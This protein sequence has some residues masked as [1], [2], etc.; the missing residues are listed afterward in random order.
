M[1]SPVYVGAF[2]PPPPPEVEGCDIAVLCCL[3]YFFFFKLLLFLK[4]L[5]IR[6]T[7]VG[8]SCRKGGARR[9]ETSGPTL[10]PKAPGV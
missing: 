9:L 1:T 4:G 3:M 2:M 10:D 5:V 6:R 8:Y 7:A